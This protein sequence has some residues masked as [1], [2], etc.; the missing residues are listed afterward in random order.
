MA[1]LPSNVDTGSPEFMENAGAMQSL[2]DR[3]NS[4]LAEIQGGGGDKARARHEE[5]GSSQARNASEKRQVGSHAGI[6]FVEGSRMGTYGTQG[7]IFV[8][9]QLESR[10]GCRDG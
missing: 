8:G 9:N 5:R 7:Q 10:H 4:T 1:Q 6:R 2:V 3:L